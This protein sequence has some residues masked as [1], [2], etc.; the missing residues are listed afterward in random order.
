MSSNVRRTPSEVNERNARTGSNTF[1]FVDR[2]G[3][4]QTGELRR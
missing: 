4:V 2:F 3:V 1:V